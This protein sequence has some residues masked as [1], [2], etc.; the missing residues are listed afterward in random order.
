MASPI[1]TVDPATGRP[2]AVYEPFDE[3][4]IARAVDDATT[5]QRAWSAWA[6]PDRARVFE[7]AARLLR[8]RSD[9]LAALITVE[10]GK[11][12]A[13][14]AAEIDKC[15]GACE[16]YAQR[17]AAWLADEVIETSAERSWIGYEPL[18]TVLAVMPWNFPFWQVFRF[19]APALMAGNAALLKH[20][21]NTTGCALAIERLLVD[22][23]LPPGLF[24]AL[25]VAET[26]VPDVIGRLL[27]DPGIS[28]VSLTGSN[29]AG[30]AVAA[31]AG[32]AT[33]K[34]VLELGGSD[35][36]VVLA[37][38]DLR[39]AAAMATRS[40]FLNAGQSCIAAKRF[41]VEAPVAARFTELF[42]QAVE[43]LVVGDPTSEGT[44][45]GPLAREDLRHGLERQV[46]ESVSAGAKVLTGGRRIERPGWFYQPTVV[47]DVRPGMPLYDE[48]TFGPVAAVIVVDDADHAAQVADD[49]P[50][51]LAMSVWTADPVAGQALARKVRS[52][53]VFINAVVASDVRMSF[54]GIGRSGY[55][56]ELG[57]A[58]IREFVNART[59]WTAREAVR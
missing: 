24:T 39:H 2:L 18:G 42:V 36:F 54:G 56:R 47:T 38:A 45:V 5:A 51:G 11:P 7:Q 25:L 35:P 50:Y 12:L 46:R 33:K 4:Q 34:S 23:G 1:T 15:T 19:A 55:G 57:Q 16:F 43:R 26:D 31:A 32:R 41:I 20:S 44:D 17:S 9:V 29:A 40:R 6:L 21:P 14:A 58:G 37:D 28:A 3:A 22:A 52:G 49:T 59:W 30:S 27:A 48:E 13:Q 53:A 8:E 10:M